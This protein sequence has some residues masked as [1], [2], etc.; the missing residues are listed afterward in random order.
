MSYGYVR[1]VQPDEIYHHGVLGQKWGKKNGPPYPLG[2]SDHS[3]SERKA[4]WR[5]SIKDSSGNRKQKIKKGA[6]I[7]AATAAT[8]ATVAS[9]AAGVKSAKD[10]AKTRERVNKISGKSSEKTDHSN[11]AFKP[12]KDGKPS[13]VEKIARSSNETVNEFKKVANNKQNQKVK[14]ASYDEVHK[15]SDA[16]LNKKI[17]RMAR[18]KR[19]RDLKYEQDLISQGSSKTA[20]ILDVVGTATVLASSAAT[21]ATA[22]YAI[23]KGI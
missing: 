7:A 13:R 17:D 21:I 8:A 3:A 16:E 23:K 4:G 5:K 2:A 11:S 9:T 10:A 12:G 14:K 15:M 22:V 18:E 19:Y 6:K 1:P 20:E